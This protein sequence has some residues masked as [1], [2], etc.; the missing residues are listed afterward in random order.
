MIAAAKEQ[1]LSEKKMSD[2][3]AGR[4]PTTQPSTQPSMSPVTIQSGYSSHENVRSIK[5]GS[6]FLNAARS[7]SGDIVFK[8]ANTM[9]AGTQNR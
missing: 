1:E 2:Q 6:V 4:E 5:G 7:G 9:S 8:T 3:Y